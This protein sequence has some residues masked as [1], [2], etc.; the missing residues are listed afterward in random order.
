MKHV[1]KAL[2]W[3]TRH[4]ELRYLES[5]IVKITNRLEEEKEELLEIINKRD[6][7]IE[8]QKEVKQFCS[9]FIKTNL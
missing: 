8:E 2:K 9:I 1:I 3:A 5:E 4:D 7:L 6:K